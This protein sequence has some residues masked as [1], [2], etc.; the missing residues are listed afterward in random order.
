[1]TVVTGM[2]GVMCAPANLHSDDGTPP[3]QQP[4]S[5]ASQEYH[6]AVLAEKG[7]PERGKRLFEDARRAACVN[8]HSLAG[9]G[10]KIGPD[11]SGVGGERSSRAELLD[12]I[13]DPSA[14]IHPDYASTIVLLRSGKI[15][16]GIL[17][18]ISDTEVEVVTSATE[19]VRFER[20]E[21]EEQKPSP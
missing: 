17:R 2:L 6:H 7:S 12:A 21:I 9:Q 18:A 8:C 13:I 1:M 5:A 14:K 15:A 4:V 3:A 19:T 10:G 11:L 16:Q 20:R